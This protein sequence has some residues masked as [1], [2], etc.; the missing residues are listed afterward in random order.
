MSVSRASKLSGYPRSSHYYKPMQRD[1]S[2]S[3]GT[4]EIVRR[5]AMMIETIESEALSHPS[6]GVRRIAAMLRRSGIT[7]SRKR[8]YRLMKLTN[9]VKKRRVRKHLVRRRELVV[10]KGPNELWEEDITYIWCGVDGWSYLFNILD[11]FTNA[12]LSHNLITKYILYSNSE[13]T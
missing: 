7:V 10:P 6:Y 11:C 8:V 9:L 12:S 1:T 5:E 2:T 4:K 13:S 3:E